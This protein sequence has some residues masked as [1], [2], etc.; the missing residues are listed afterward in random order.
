MSSITSKTCIITNPSARGNR[1]RFFSEQR[2]EWCQ[3]GVVMETCGPG[4]AEKLASKAVQNGFTT[5]IAA[6]GDGTVYEVLW[7]PFNQGGL[8]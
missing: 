6:G 1:A 2:Q 8:R 7:T 3:M 4:D 5:V